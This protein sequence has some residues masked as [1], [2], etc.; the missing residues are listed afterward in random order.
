MKPLGI[1][2]TYRKVMAANGPAQ[3]L[4][5]SFWGVLMA[6]MFSGLCDKCYT[7][8][9]LIFWGAVSAS[10]TPIT[11]WCKQTWLRNVLLLDVVVSAY[12]L[13]LFLMPDPHM[14]MQNVY[15]TSTATGMIKANMGESHGLSD[16][17]HAVS[18]IW[19]TLHALYLADLTNRQVLE[20]KR[21]SHDDI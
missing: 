17:F 5:Y 16:W 14:T 15:Y 1:R 6:G 7:Q 3:M 10:V 2:G 9:L 8:E 12:I 13:V 4:T 18:V 11:I 21:F 19:M 20:K